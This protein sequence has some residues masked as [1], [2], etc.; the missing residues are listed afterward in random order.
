MYIRTNFILPTV[1][2]P[3]DKK[4]RKEIL[5]CIFV[6]KS[7]GSGQQLGRTYRKGS[8][9]RKITGNEK[10]GSALKKLRFGGRRIIPFHAPGKYFR[11]SC[12]LRGRT[13]LIGNPRP[14]SF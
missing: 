13:L 8:L 5:I 11:S 2:R 12:R 1:P 3:N 9:E 14:E 7:E 4:C 10:V 6:R